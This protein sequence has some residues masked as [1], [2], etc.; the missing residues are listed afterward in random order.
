MSQLYDNDLQID[1]IKCGRFDNNAYLLKNINTNEGIIIDAPEEPENIISQ[2]GDTQVIAILI[3]HNHMDHIAGLEELRLFTKAPVWVHKA[4]SK[5]ISPSAERHLAGGESLRIGQLEI[6]SIYTP[7]HTPGS[8]S[9]IVNNHLFTGDTLFPG[10]PGHSTSPEN[11]ATIIQSLEEKIFPLSNDIHVYPGHGA[12][13]DLK[14]CREEYQ[15]FANKSH[16]PDLHGD[17]LWLSS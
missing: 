6:H 7:G 10:G 4:D 9:Y 2:I 13:T 5:A 16:P 11:L 12:D 8:T 1:T 14:T 3:T 15:I 17:I